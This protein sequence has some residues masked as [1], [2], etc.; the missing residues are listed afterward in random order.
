MR[1]YH[2]DAIHREIW[3]EIIRSCRK[4]VMVLSYGN[5]DMAQ[6]NKLM[7]KLIPNLDETYSFQIFHLCSNV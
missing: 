1:S 3:L 5:F 4:K 7:M 2:C 6:V